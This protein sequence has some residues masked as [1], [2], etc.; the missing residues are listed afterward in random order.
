MITS[1]ARRIS[2]RKA[3]SLA[4]GSDTVFYRASLRGRIDPMSRRFQFSLLWFLVVMLAPAVFY[5]GYALGRWHEANKLRG[6]RMAV[7]AREKALM[8]GEEH[9]IR[10]LNFI[11]KRYPDAADQTKP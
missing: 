5:G 4:M 2:F 3:F 6:E 7:E 1:T 9:L 8:A 10:Q 11:A